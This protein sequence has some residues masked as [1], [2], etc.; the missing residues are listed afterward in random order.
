MQ[1]LY[2]VFLAL[3]Y[4]NSAFANGTVTTYWFL[5]ETSHSSWCGYSDE[6]VFKRDADIFKPTESASVS[7]FS[8]KIVE[9]TYQL[10]PESG[11]WIVVD[12]YNI[13]DKGMT[14][15][16]ANLLAQENLEVIQKLSAVDGR[17][18]FK[19]ERIT[20]L[21]GK[22]AAPKS[23]DYPNVPVMQNLTQFPFSSLLVKLESVPKVCTR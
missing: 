8:G 15:T 4:S 5:M 16:R 9:I 7:L 17:S 3:A 1:R 22:M 19:V 10:Q 13:S 12:K 14:L 11:D 20:T 18:K 6:M 21:N 2:I 23:I